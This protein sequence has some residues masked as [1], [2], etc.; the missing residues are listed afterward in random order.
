[1]LINELINENVTNNSNKTTKRKTKQNS[2]NVHF[3][4]GNVAINGIRTLYGF[5]GM[6]V[7]G[8]NQQSVVVHRKLDWA[9]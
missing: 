3:R 1:M 4:I 9:V 5:D 6:S 7:C 8:D 2:E